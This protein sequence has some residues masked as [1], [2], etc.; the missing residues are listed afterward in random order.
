M[1]TKA[2][3]SI[4]KAPYSGLS[5][6]DIRFCSVHEEDTLHKRTFGTDTYLCQLEHEN[7]E[8]SGTP[9]WMMDDAQPGTD[10]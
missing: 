1:A 6:T 8:S 4:E 2:E 7:I 9:G 3:N 5:K 10:K